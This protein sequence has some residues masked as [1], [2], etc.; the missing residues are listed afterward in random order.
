MSIPEN[1][2]RVDLKAG[3]DCGR[4]GIDFIQTDVTYFFLI[5]Q[6]IS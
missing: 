4:A 1:R 5:T 6:M 2:T 3:R